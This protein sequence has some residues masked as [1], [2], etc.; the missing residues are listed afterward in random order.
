MWTHW[1][2]CVNICFPVWKRFQ[3]KNM[4]V[5]FAK[6]VWLKW[7]IWRTNSC[8]F[9][10]EPIPSWDFQLQIARYIFVSF[11]F[12][13]SNKNECVFFFDK[14]FSDHSLHISMHSN[15]YCVAP[16]GNRIIRELIIYNKPKIN[17][18]HFISMWMRDRKS[19][20][21]A[22]SCFNSFNSK[23]NNKQQISLI[24]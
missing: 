12:H 17:R 3:R 11:T 22:V 2:R 5:P 9:F 24:L 18:N 4:F 14:F 16:N 21:I 13:K 7:S 10:F 6:S 19:S 15:C 8:I 1:W 20:W 23:C